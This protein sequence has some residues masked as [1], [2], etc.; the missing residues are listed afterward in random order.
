MSHPGPQA[1]RR[2]APALSE[3]PGCDTLP[4]LRTVAGHAA[5]AKTI[6]S[7]LPNRVIVATRIFFLKEENVQ[8]TAHPLWLACIHPCDLPSGVG[9]PN[10]QRRRPHARGRQP[11]GDQ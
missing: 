7:V 1:A 6:G 2:P 8:I 9:S 3:L 11:A 10:L 5:P 4:P